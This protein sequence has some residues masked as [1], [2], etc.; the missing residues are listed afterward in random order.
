[1]VEARFTSEG[2]LDVGSTYDQV[3]R[4]L[5]R[6]VDSTFEVIAYEPGRMVKAT[7]TAGSFPITFTRMVEPRETGCRVTAIIEGSAGGFFKLAEPLLARM[8]QR[9]VEGDYANLKKVLEA[10]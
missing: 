6:Q 10:G 9:S 2:P 8:V 3:A 4:F 7:S 5:G 1:M